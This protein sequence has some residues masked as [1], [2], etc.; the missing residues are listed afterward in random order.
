LVKHQRSIDFDRRLSCGFQRKREN[1]VEWGFETIKDIL[2]VVVVPIALTVLAFV[3]P[4][5]QARYRRRAFTE[6]ILRELEELT[7]FPEAKQ[8][9]KH[10]WDHQIRSFVHQKVFED[11]SNNREFILSLDPNLVYWVTQ[12]WAALDDHDG[13]QWLFYLRRIAEEYDKSGKIK[14]A[15]RKWNLLIEAYQATGKKVAAP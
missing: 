15:L 7:P 6:L 11:A 5:I 13:G 9:D 12:L 2:D 3:W 10:W 4:A 14:D 8:T 1:I